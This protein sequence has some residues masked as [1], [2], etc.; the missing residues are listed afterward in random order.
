MYCHDKTLN[1][2]FYNFSGC[3]G[4][5]QGSTPGALYSG[6]AHVICKNHKECSCMQS[7]CPVPMNSTF[8]KWRKIE[9]EPLIHCRDI[10]FL[11]T[12]S[13][14]SEEQIFLVIILSREILS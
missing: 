3:I 7:K 6:T 4:V 12:F 5:I 9:E 2:Y 11:H 14:I 13:L 1:S 8:S 10:L